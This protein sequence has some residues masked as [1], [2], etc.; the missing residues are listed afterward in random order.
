MKRKTVVPLILLVA[1]LCGNVAEASHWTPPGAGTIFMHIAGR[2]TIDG[3]APQSGDELGVFG[4]DGTLIGL[5]Q[6]DGS[7]GFLYGDVAISGDD[8]NTPGENEGAQEGQSLSVKVWSAKNG[9]E[10]SG[11]EIQLIST[12]EFS[13]HGYS[14]LALPLVFKENIFKG[15]NIS[16]KSNPGILFPMN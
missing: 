11:N 4:S 10:Y 1:V 3:K 13:K 7:T 14:D 16:V 12:D 6:V 2:L 8:P 15:I 5:H 9:R